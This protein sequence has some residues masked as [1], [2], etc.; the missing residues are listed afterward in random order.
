MSDSPST[1]TTEDFVLTVAP[2][3]LASILEIRDTEEDP[4][5]VC[6]RVEITGVKGVEYDYDLGW[7]TISEL[8]PE[9]DLSVQSGLSVVVAAASV[10]KM[11][12]AVLDLPRA[13]GQGGF[14]IKNPNRPA[15]VNPLEGRDIELTGDIP[16]K[17]TQLLEEVINPGLAQHGG[18]AALVGVDDTTVFLTMGG[19]CQGCAMSAATLRDGISSS[20]QESIPEVTEVIDVT[21][22]T[23]GDN[24]F[25]T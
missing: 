20:I 4:G 23:A 6:L 7:S 12:G 9:D 14:V 18:F 16:D 11:H 1:A 22:H 25:Y 17:V 2:E 21:D 8:D 5:A 15:P 3:A 13:A 19:G 24:P 10:E